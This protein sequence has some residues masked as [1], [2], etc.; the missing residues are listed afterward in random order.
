MSTV[1]ANTDIVLPDRVL[2]DG[3]LRGDGNIIAEIGEG[4]PPTSAAMVRLGGHTLA[5]GFVDIH[6]HGGGGSSFQDADPGDVAAVADFHRRRGTTTMVASLMTRPLADLVHS[7]AALREL[8]ADGIV[9]GVHVEGPFLAAA[10]CGAHSPDLL[11][12]PSPAAVDALL[13]AGEGTLAMITLAPEL[14]GGIAAVRRISDAGVLPAI[15][16]TN[17][18]YDTARRAIGAG[19]RVATHL[20]NGM[21]PIHHREPGPAVALLEDPGGTIEIIHDRKH[22]HDSIVTGLFSRLPSGRLAL[23]SDAIAAA[24]LDTG[25]YDVDGLEVT[26]HDGEARLTGGG[27]LAGSAITLSD[28]VRH[29]LTAGGDRHSVLTAAS[30]TPARTLGLEDQAG[31]IRVGRR[32]DLVAL[33]QAHQVVAVMSSG[34]WLGRPPR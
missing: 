20:F 12:A 6:V 30:R 33:D 19:A 17:A 7:L 9:A 5:P 22:L 3:W 13:S 25:R 18:S 21:R 16:H 31:S 24:G 10:H 34:Q 8:V 1:I 15:G 28:A 26:V 14:P 27:P 23:V 32:A 4:A 11:R 29:S 2:E